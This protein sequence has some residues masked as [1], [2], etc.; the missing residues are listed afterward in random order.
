VSEAQLT[1]YIDLMNA[2]DEL[3]DL[4]GQTY[5]PVPVVYRGVKGIF[6]PETSIAQKHDERQVAKAWRLSS[7]AQPF[8]TDEVESAADKWSVLVREEVKKAI[9]EYDLVYRLAEALKK[10]SI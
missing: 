7:L 3:K 6:V 8:T 4:E 10:N 5:A 9:D 1:R 2:M